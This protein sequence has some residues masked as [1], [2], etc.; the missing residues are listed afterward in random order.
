MGDTGLE[1]PPESP[2][3]TAFSKSRDAE[4]DA[5]RAPE[6][7]ADDRPPTAGDSDLR[8]VVEAWPTLPEPVK[9]GILA[10][11]AVA[12]QGTK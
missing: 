5:P 1:H 8:R 12:E 2:E 3:I 11:I 9:A 7:V 6:P 4:S 10:M